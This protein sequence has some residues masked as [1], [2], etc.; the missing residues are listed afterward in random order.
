MCV[1]HGFYFSGSSYVTKNIDFEIFSMQCLA[2]FFFQ[3]NHLILVVQ[4]PQFILCYSIIN[5]RLQ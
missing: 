4:R 5:E 1:S 2:T 3:M